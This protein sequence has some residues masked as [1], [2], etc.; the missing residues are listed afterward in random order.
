MRMAINMRRGKP[1][2]RYTET[3]ICGNYYKILGTQPHMRWRDLW[4]VYLD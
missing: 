3:G 4:V 1:A 2:I